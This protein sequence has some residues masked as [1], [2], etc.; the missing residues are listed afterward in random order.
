MIR[1]FIFT[2]IAS[3]IMSACSASGKTDAELR[4]NQKADS[5]MKLMT[6]DEKNCQMALYFSGWTVIDPTFKSLYSDDIHKGLCVNIF[7]KNTAA[8]TRK[9]K[10]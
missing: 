5:G 9:L 7:N 2:F 4:I 8:F 3:S 10:K 1:N 6:L